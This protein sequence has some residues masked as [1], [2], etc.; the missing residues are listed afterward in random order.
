MPMRL[1]VIITSKLVKTYFQLYL[2][3]SSIDLL[4]PHMGKFANLKIMLKSLKQIFYVY[5]YICMCKA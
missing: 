1:Q 2:M 4:P 3:K 5:I